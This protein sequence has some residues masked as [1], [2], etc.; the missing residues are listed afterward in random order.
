MR[1]LDYTQVLAEFCSLFAATN[2]CLSSV[3]I[4][5]DQSAHSHKRLMAV[6]MVVLLKERFHW[7]SERARTIGVIR[8]SLRCLMLRDSSTGA[9]GTKSGRGQCET[10]ALQIAS[11]GPL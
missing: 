6:S 7:I 5:T 2:L 1:L 8:I 4:C 9:S 10:R 3:G 11:G